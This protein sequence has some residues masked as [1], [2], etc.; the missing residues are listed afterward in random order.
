MKKK[1]YDN[2]LRI[3]HY[4]YIILTIILFII[5]YYFRM[6]KLLEIILKKLLIFLQNNSVIFS[7]I[8]IFYIVHLFVMTL[9]LKSI[10]AHEETI[11]EIERKNK[12]I[13]S[14]ISIFF[15]LLLLFVLWKIYYIIIINYFI[16]FLLA[17]G[18]K[19]LPIINYFIFIKFSLYLS[20]IIIMKIVR[21][22]KERIKIKKVE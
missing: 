14:L 7:S 19:C 16:Y 22:N 20:K 6:I 18:F 9:I 5:F 10:K 2:K 8:L 15:S 11:Y 1:E 3:S 12:I 17:I 21:N 13:I 4:K